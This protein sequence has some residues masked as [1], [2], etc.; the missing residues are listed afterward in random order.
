[1][2]TRR[3]G[4]LAT[5]Y[6]LPPSASN[7]LSLFTFAFLSLSVNFHPKIQQVQPMSV[8]FTQP[9]QNEVT[10]LLALQAA[11]LLA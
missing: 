10:R 2:A 4:F 8:M 6:S 1:L 3:L 5:C 7:Y 9:G 11:D